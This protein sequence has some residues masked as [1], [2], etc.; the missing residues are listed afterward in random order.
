MLI[1]TATLSYDL[2]KQ[3]LILTATISCNLLKQMLI[4]TATISNN[5]SCKQQPVKQCSGS[6]MIYIPFQIWIWNI[7][8]QLTIFK[9]R[10]HGET[11]SLLQF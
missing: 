4:L 11:N 6:K 3:M 9:K 2:L 8:A 5:H 7:A 10:G 1:S